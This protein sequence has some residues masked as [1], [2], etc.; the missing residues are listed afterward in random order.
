MKAINDE[1]ASILSSVKQCGDF[2]STGRLD[3]TIPNVEIEGIG[4]IAFPLLPTQAK[5]IVAIASRS[6][7]GRGED[8]IVD[9]N[10]R[11]TWQ[12]APDKVNLT[13]RSWSKSLDAIVEKVSAGLGVTSTVSAELYKL[14]VY[15][16]GSFFVEHRDTEKSAGMFATLVVTLPSLCE[17]GELVVRHGTQEVSL[18]LNNADLECIPFAAFYADC[19]HEVRPVTC[20]IRQRGWHQALQNP[21]RKQKRLRRY[22]SDGN[23][24]LRQ[25]AVS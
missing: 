24:G 16:E 19:V 9:T 5:Q 17:G 12:I 14:L 25:Q 4:R 21:R 23:D 1:L 6:P 22:W 15:D 18:D 8:T 10:V 2:Y 3:A 20:C 11:R 7:F 13:G